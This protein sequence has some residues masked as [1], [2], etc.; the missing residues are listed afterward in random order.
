M[1]EPAG[2][3]VALLTYRGNPYSG[4]QGVYVKQLSRAL[5]EL[6]HHVEVLSAQ[7]Y[8]VV[9]PRVTL[10]EVP[11]LDLYR[12]DN[13]YRIPEM[14]EFHDWIDELEFEVMF[15]GRFPEPLVFSYRARRLLQDRVA[16]FDVV[17][18]NQCLGTGIHEMQGDGHRVLATIH[19]PLAVDLE[20]ARQRGPEAAASAELFYGFLSMQEEVAKMM[21]VVITV[22]EAA[23]HDIVEKVGI[24]DD[25]MRVIPLGVDRSIFR[26]RPEI[27]PEPGRVLTMA[28][29]NVPLKGLDC[30]L[31]AMAAVRREVP[32]AHLAVVSRT[33]E[34]SGIPERL[35]ELGLTGAVTRLMDLTEEQ[36]GEEFSRSEV[37]VVPSLYE[38][39]SLP[40]AQAMAAGVPL[41]GT[42]AGALP[43]VIGENGTTGLLV[44]PG[45][46]LPMA[47]AIA[48]LLL[49]RAL[50]TRLGKAG[51]ERAGARYD[52][53]TCAERTAAVYRELIG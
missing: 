44:E 22:S 13:P 14:S 47:E 2:L 17:H 1:P 23:R 16:E 36:L 53:H 34:E 28:A 41:V 50:R 29:A 3:R 4:G 21:P 26:P 15:S 32:S 33:W 40:A 7:P 51:R 6:G 12:A 27:A 25:R 5:V 52:W 45:Q 24:A 20:L 38:G 9:D 18:D 43:E 49:D 19:H 31:Q 39:F 8:P 42:T 30:L 37:I 10:T 35:Q 48:A 46:P 11:G